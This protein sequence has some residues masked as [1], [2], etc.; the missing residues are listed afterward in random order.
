[1]TPQKK[2]AKKSQSSMVNN[3]ISNNKIGQKN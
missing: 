2:K 1:M 3:L